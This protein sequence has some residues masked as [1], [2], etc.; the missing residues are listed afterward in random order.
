[1]NRLSLPRKTSAAN[2]RGARPRRPDPGG[3]LVP[4]VAAFGALSLVGWW[5]GL[6]TAIAAFAAGRGPG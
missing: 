1:M 4:A 6:P 3:V 5:W 2:G